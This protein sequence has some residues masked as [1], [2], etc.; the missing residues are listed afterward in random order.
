MTKL[1]Q[2]TGEGASEESVYSIHFS[3]IR[4]AGRG[5]G[6]GHGEEALEG[7]LQLILPY[8]CLPERLPSG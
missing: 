6:C 7:G 2:G 3:M 5:K 1:H 4:A 8:S